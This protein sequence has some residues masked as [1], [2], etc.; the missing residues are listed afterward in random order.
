MPIDYWA[1]AR[2]TSRGRVTKQNKIRNKSCEY[3]NASFR[4][5]IYFI[6][7]LL[8]L[9]L[10]FI[11]WTREKNNFLFSF[12]LLWKFERI[13]PGRWA[14]RE[15]DLILNQLWVQWAVLEYSF[16][17]HFFYSGKFEEKDTGKYL[18][19]FQPRFCPKP[20]SIL[21]YF[22]GDREKWVIVR[23]RVVRSFASRSAVVRFILYDIIVRL[24]V[25]HSA[26][27]IG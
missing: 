10:F 21:I 9:F 11:L 3:L 1:I 12:V 22:L 17:Y 13:P 26:Y 16:N 25:C 5:L 20:F 15:L 2:V 19:I 27:Y 24:R 7:S 23:S 6:S 4:L 18:K 8:F 14:G